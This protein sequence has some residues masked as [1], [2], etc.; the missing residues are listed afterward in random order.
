MYMARLFFFPLPFVSLPLFALLVLSLIVH[1]ERLFLFLLPIFSL[2]PALLSSFLFI[3]CLICP[4]VYSHPHYPI[5][6]L[7]LFIY[8]PIIITYSRISDRERLRKKK[9]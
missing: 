1:L 3:S 9:S 5:I 7:S 4:L 6:P 2:F 8:L